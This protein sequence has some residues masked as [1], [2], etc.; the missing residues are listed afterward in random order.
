VPRFPPARRAARRFL[1]GERLG[2]ALGAASQIE[3]AG[4]GVVLTHLG[5]DVDDPE[6]VEEVVQEYLRALDRI[7]G[8]GLDV[9]ISVKLSQL[10]LSLG[11]GVC[12]AA[13][14]RLAEAAA[15][16]GSY[17]WI[18][19][20]RSGD[21]DATLELFGE[22]LREFGP[23]GVCL[24]AYLHRT[25]PDIDRLL[26]P[27]FHGGHP[28]GIR[29]VKGAYQEPS[30]VALQDRR[31]IDQRFEELALRLLIRREDPPGLRLALGTHDERLI[32][33]L[34]S[35]VSAAGASVRDR[36][37]E[38]HLLYGIRRDLQSY[39]MRRATPLRILI[40][41]GEAWYPWFVRRL[42]ERPA[43]LLLLARAL[44]PGGMD[45]KG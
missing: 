19:M 2:E 32:K 15:R 20:E 33:E 45:A 22:I 3:E 14:G 6:G 38:F 4:A 9:E 25:P 12:R 23:A 26:A 34:R 1:P 31:A 27:D 29:L 18:D 13:L 16:T 28:P 36:A 11:P 40:N 30:E 35:D 37:V 41:Y 8:Q 44:L 21:V 7:A 24:Q 42:A 17:L 5:E 39:L 43:N 10:G